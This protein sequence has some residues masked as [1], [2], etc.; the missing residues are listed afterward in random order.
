MWLGPVGLV[1]NF[2]EPRSL[3]E[4][5]VAGMDCRWRMHDGRRRMQGKIHLP[6]ICSRDGLELFDY[7]R[8][9]DFWKNCDLFPARRNSAAVEHRQVGD[10]GTDTRSSMHVRARS[11]TQ[12]KTIL[13]DR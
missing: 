10:I 3:G 4:Y 2:F 13:N 8:A 1:P 12:H 9:I 6:W 5:P 7:W 11:K